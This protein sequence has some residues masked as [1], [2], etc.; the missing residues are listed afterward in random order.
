MK[1]YDKAGN[2]YSTLKEYRVGSL[3]TNLKLSL[4]KVKARVPKLPHK[5]NDVVEEP[6]YVEHAEPLL[7]EEME[8][9]NDDEEPTEE[10]EESYTPVTATVPADAAPSNTDG[11]Y[12]KIEIDYAHECVNLFNAEGKVIASTPIDPNLVRNTIDADLADA[13]FGNAPVPEEI[14]TNIESIPTTEDALMNEVQEQIDDIHSGP[15][16]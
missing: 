16:G 9:R 6:P 13:L 5:E 15:V 3:K 4:G 8:N 2:E 1:F 11:T 14:R 10:V 7:P 12:T